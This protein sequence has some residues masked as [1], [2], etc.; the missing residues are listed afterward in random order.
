LVVLLLSIGATAIWLIVGEGK[1][2]DSAS[3][4][5]GQHQ[6]LGDLGTSTH[7]P[8]KP[9]G[10]AP[11]PGIT[12]FGAKPIRIHF[13]Q[14]PRAGVVLD[15]ATGQVLWAQHPLKRLPIASLTKIMTAIIVVERTPPNE[16]A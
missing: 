4:I 11:P 3:S 15:M 16:R 8:A 6:A 9:S 1:T 10:A 2:S 13:K 5:G 7:P 14:P 12:L